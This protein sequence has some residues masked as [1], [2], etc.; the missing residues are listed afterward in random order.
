M[1]YCIEMHL[2]WWQSHSKFGAL[3]EKEQNQGKDIVV[4]IFKKYFQSCR[5]YEWSYFLQVEINNINMSVPP[6][7]V[8]TV[9]TWSCLEFED[10][11]AVEAALWKKKY[12]T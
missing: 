9:R 4:G 11:N 10:Q 3:E 1:W 5:C 2:S 8:K 6:R 7:Y 12:N